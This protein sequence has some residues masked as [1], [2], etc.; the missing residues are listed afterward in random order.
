MQPP[1]ATPRQRDIAASIL[2]RFTEGKPLNL[3]AM[4]REDPGLVAEVFA[5]RPFWGWR[6]ALESAGLSYDA[7]AFD[8]E[9]TVECLVCGKRLR[10]L[11][12]HLNA[13]HGLSR[14]AYRAEFPGAF[15]VSEVLRAGRMRSPGFVPHWE[16][17]WSAEYVVDRIRYLHDQGHKVNSESVDAL[18]TTLLAAARTYWGAW[19]RALE[20]A[21]LAPATIRQIA[22]GHPFPQEADLIAAIRS[23]YAAGLPLNSKAVEL[24]DSHLINGARRR[25]GSWTK[26]LRAAGI[27]PRDVYLGTGRGPGTHERLLNRARQVAAIADERARHRALAALRKRYT[28]IAYRGFGG[29]ASVARLIGETPELLLRRHSYTREEVLDALAKRRQAG[30][31]MTPAAVR[32]EDGPLAYAAKREFVSLPAAYVRL[33]EMPATAP[34]QAA[35]LHAAA[36]RARSRGA[37]PRPRGFGARPCPS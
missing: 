36:S 25:L 16:P 11:S 7:I 37:D 8:L 30:L 28:N 21:D 1:A 26:A 22:P 32:R 15:C 2:C 9:D 29:W 27:R 23:R 31:D 19:D 24:Q 35:P 14:G 34:E 6:R 17:I 4:K 10:L 12:G 18:D 3:T 5:M 33:G 13:V 20:A